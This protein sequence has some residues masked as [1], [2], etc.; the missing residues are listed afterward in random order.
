MLLLPN[1]YIVLPDDYFKLY[2]N[3][4]NTFVNAI[5]ESKKQSVDYYYEKRAASKPMKDIS[6]GKMGEVFAAYYVHKYLNYSFVEPDFNIY[7]SRN[8]NWNED[9]N[10]GFHVKTCDGYTC[11]FV[12]QPSWT[13]QFNNQNGS[14]GRDALFNSNG[15]D[16]IIF[17]YIDSYDKNEAVILIV[18]PWKDIKPFL[19]DPLKKSLRNIK[20]CIYYNDLLRGIINENTC[21]TR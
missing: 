4:T 19:K 6:V 9:L 5:S 21:S 10:T 15:K 18:S 14:F 17:V 20:K 1:E 8:K 3:K 12:G 11:K 16:I 2:L 13:F 7:N